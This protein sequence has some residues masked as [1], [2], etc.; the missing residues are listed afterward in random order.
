[1]AIAAF[2]FWMHTDKRQ[3]QLFRTVLAK[4]PDPGKVALEV[5][6]REAHSRK[7]HPVSEKRSSARYTTGSAGECSGGAREVPGR[8][9]RGAREVPEKVP[10]KCPRGAREGAREVP[11]RCFSAEKCLGV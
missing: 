5:A 7:K 10:G 8:C 1:M 6:T 3:A 2:C 9:P 11:E 4:V